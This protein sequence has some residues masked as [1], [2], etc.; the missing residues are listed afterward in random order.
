MFRW[1]VQQ[2]GYYVVDAQGNPVARFTE[3]R[4]KFELKLSDSLGRTTSFAF[5]VVFDDTHLQATPHLAFERVLGLDSRIR[6]LKL[7]W[8]WMRDAF[9]WRGN[10]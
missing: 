10:G 3:P 8:H 6:K 4:E 1:D 9:M 7:G 5:T 2:R